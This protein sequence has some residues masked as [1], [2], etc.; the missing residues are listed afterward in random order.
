MRANTMIDIF[1]VKLY[2][3]AKTLASA[4]EPDHVRNLLGAFKNTKGRFIIIIIIII[5]LLCR[6]LGLIATCYVP[7]VLI[8]LLQA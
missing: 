5:L 2:R 8:Y 3:R 6:Q 4:S 1:L 7:T